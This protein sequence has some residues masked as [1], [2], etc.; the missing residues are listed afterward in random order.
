MHI[1]VIYKNKKLIYFKPL[2]KPPYK[3]TTTKT[4]AKWDNIYQ[5]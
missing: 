1:H 5:D 2:R 4:T 3:T